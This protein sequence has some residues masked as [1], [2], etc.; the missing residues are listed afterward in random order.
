MSL[1]CSQ[2]GTAH[3]DDGD[4]HFCRKCGRPL[5]ASAAGGGAAPQA[6]LQPPAPAE[7]PDEVRW[8]YK[9]VTIPLNVP[10]AGGTALYMGRAAREVDQVLLDYLQQAEQEGGWQ[11]D[12]PANL[13]SL[14]RAGQ[15]EPRERGIFRPFVWVAATIRLKR[16]AP[17]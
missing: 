10:V 15:M 14:D 12:T 6:A 5:G 8:Q 17:G 11:A 3:P 16:P 4:S 1:Y 13:R 9:D 2:D 7:P